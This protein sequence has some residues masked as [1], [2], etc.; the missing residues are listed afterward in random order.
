MERQGGGI[1][2]LP[3]SR[4]RWKRNNNIRGYVADKK[5]K[6]VDNAEEEKRKCSKEGGGRIFFVFFGTERF[7][8]AEW[9]TK[10]AAANW[11]GGLQLSE[12]HKGNS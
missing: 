2:P 10:K 3:S 9:G 11:G 4:K 7:Q 12:Y 6:M 5:R 1:R 8:L